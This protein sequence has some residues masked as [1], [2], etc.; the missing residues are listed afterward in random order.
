MGRRRRWTDEQLVAAVATSKSIA[1][2]LGL[3]GLIPAGGNYVHVQRRIDELGLD[4]RHFTG[5]GWNVGLAFRPSPPVPLEEVLVKGRRTG[6]HLLKKRLVAAGLATRATT[7]SRTSASSA[8]T[9]T[10]C[11]RR[12]AG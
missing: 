5:M 4:T 11:S 2:V 10:A 6:S 8:P 12:I 9:V 7:A 1:R 3:L